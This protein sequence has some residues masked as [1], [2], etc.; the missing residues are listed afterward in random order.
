MSN[1]NFNCTSYIPAEFTG[2]TV[3]LIAAFKTKHWYYN[4]IINVLLKK[5]FNVFVYDYPWRP[6]LDAEPE[7]WV[8]FSERVTKDIDSKIIAEKNLHPM[9]RFGII[10]VS[11]GSA[12]AMHAAK[13]LPALEKIMLVT[14]YG[15]SALHVWE[16]PLLEKMRDKFE[17]S[18]R[19]IKDA[20]AVFGYLEPLSHIEL[21]GHRK[22][23]LYTNERDP[24]IKFSNTSLFIDEAQK[25]HIN[26]I[27]RRIS[28]RRHS[29]T[30]LKVFKEPVLWVP[31]F[32]GL[33]HRTPATY[34]QHEFM[35][36]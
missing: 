26:L 12:L 11:V 31:F 28:A 29:M 32:L 3:F 33:K 16:H 35:V 13:T 17:S 2:G 14:L 21:I 19:G 36:G 4:P 23:L 10:G 30:I 24:V 8:E 15:S 20:A 1:L 7:E 18:G 25:H 27:V 22:I 34:Q 9:A 6:L 5:G